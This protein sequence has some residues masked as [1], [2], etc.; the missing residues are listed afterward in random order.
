[1]A[2]ITATPN[3]AGT[4]GATVTVAGTAFEQ[5]QTRILLDG[6]AATATFRPATDGTFSQPITVQS[7]AGTQTVMAQQCVAGTFTN[8]IGTGIRIE[9]SVTSA[10]VTVSATSA[11]TAELRLSAYAVQRFLRHGSAA[12]TAALAVMDDAVDLITYHWSGGYA[13]S[14]QSA[15]QLA[16]SDF[17][18]T[19][20]GSARAWGSFGSRQGLD[21]GFANLDAL[22]ATRPAAKIALVMFDHPQ[23]MLNGQTRGTQRN[24]PWPSSTYW[25][26]SYAGA[27]CSEIIA[28]YPG[29]ILAFSYGQELKGF[30]DR[31][32]LPA[33][34][35]FAAGFTAWATYMRTNHPTIE[36]WYPHLN[37]FATATLAQR[38]TAVAAL[39]A[40]GSTLQAA[41]ETIIN[42][43]MDQV[44]VAHV[45][46]MTYDVSII[47]YNT[48]DPWRNYAA[49][50][51]RVD[52][53]KNLCRVLKAKMTSRWGVQ[54]P[55]VAIESYFDVNQVMQDWATE[56]QSAALATAIAIGA[57][58][59]GVTY[60]MR[61]EPEGGDPG[62]EAPDGNIASW[63]TKAGVALPAWTQIKDL[64]VNIPAGTT[65]KVTTVAD[66]RIKAISSATKVYLLNMSA[67]AVDVSVSA[68]G[69]NLAA[70]SVPAFGY[71]VRTL[72]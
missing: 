33:L 69:G 10:T 2:A 1:M 71:L 28:R 35:A 13:N 56:A 45:D 48:S 53:E 67:T 16:T 15:Q 44:S 5:R 72:P 26:A 32:Y 46:R 70:A 36:L 14:L 39:L 29:K 54:K 43:L 7:A 37:Y 24:F 64:V 42:R 12:K 63:W 40:G 17:A 38:A 3:P 65:L 52:L 60:H 68:P 47:D 9:G 20:M 51:S 31:T 50:S 25:G 21:A 57:M 6:V 22:I 27:L 18:P 41:D 66:S 19:S 34:D 11:G 23:A 59:E 49:A 4:G 55:L 62:A 58:S 61:W 8:I 30:G